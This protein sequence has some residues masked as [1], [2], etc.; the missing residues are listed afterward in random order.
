M[1]KTLYEEIL[2]INQN[3][4]K[5]EEES[6]WPKFISSRIANSQRKR[7]L[8][9]INIMREKCNALSVT[10]IE[11][12]M[13]DVL[14]YNKGSYGNIFWVKNI[15]DEDKNI[16][17]IEGCYIDNSYKAIFKFNNKL[18]HRSPSTKFDLH[19]TVKTDFGGNKIVNDNY[20]LSLW[21]IYS[22]N[23]KYKDILYELNKRITN[24]MC[25]YLE[26]IINKDITLDIKQ[27]DI[28]IDLT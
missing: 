3:I 4:N 6:K 20:N 5:T 22:T 16:D 18:S 15:I 2:N 14:L 19:L 11:E 12:F 27:D 25:D 8:N 26:D 9:S 13:L 10:Y 21:S 23:P 7:L 17:M 1:E 28:T 24:E